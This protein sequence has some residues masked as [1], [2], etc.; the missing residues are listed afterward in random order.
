[1]TPSLKQ[2]QKRIET[3]Q[4]D[5]AGF[6]KRFS[7]LLFFKAGQ[8]FLELFDAE[9]LL[10]ISKGAL[11][12]MQNKTPEE[13][14]VRVYNP[15]FAVEGWETAYTVLELTLKDRPF[16]VD[17]IRAALRRQGL[18][19]YHLLH[20]ILQVSRDASGRITGVSD[21]GGEGVP[22]AYEFYLID[23]IEDEA[24][25]QELQE[26]VTEVLQDVVLATDDYPAMRAQAVTMREYLGELRQRSA[27]EGN[28]TLA[29]ELDEFEAFMAW[30]DADNF[31]FLGY[32]EYD[33]FPIEGVPHLQVTPDSGL[34]ILRKVGQSAY[35]QP[36]PMAQ[37]PQGLRERVTGGRLLLVTKTN[38]ESTLHRAARMDYIGIKKVNADWSVQG[39]QRFLGLFTSKALSAPVEEIP[40]LRRKLRQVLELDRAIPG[41]HDFK[42]IVAIFNS[43][44]REELFW[45]DAERLHQDIRTIMEMERERGVRLTL[46]PDP[47]SRGL[48]AMVIMARDRFNTEVRRRIQSLLT[49]KLHATHVDYQLAMGEDEDQVRF[50]FFFT[51][52][53]RLSELDLQELEHD[54][55]ELT[56]TWEE[57][58]LERI[59]ASRGEME[60]RQLAER[61]LK[62]FDERYKA[63]NSAGVALRDIENI[64]ALGD[65]PYRVDI[66]NPLEDKYGEGATQLKIYHQERTLVLSEVLPLLENLGFRVLEQISYFAQLKE[67]SGAQL[68][69]ID[70]FR[71]QTLSGEM[72]DVRQHAPRL[73]E[74][75]LTLLETRAENDS[76][77]RLVLYGG[78][79]IRQ[80]ALLRAY[81]MYYAQLNAE[82]SRSFINATLVAHP[83]IAKLLYQVFEVRFDPKVSGDREL[84]TGEV[85]EAFVDSL[86][87]VSS[88]PE[89][90]TL[91]GLF[92][93]M[94]ASVRTNFF[95]GKPFISFKLRSERVDAM[96]EPRPMFEIGVSGPGV[97]GTHLRGGKVARGG[98]RWSDRTDD[99]RTEVLGLMKTQMTKNAVIVPVG[100][101]GGFVVK[102]APAER[103]ALRAYVQEQYRTFIRGL[104]DLTDN[105]VDGQVVHLEGL[106]IHDEPDPYLVVAADKGTATFSDLANEIS[107]EYGFWL[108]DAFASGGSYG[109]DHKKEGITARGAWESVKRH[110]RELGVNIMQE[111]FTVFGIGDMSGDVF[112]NGMLYT[113]TIKL[114]AAFNHLHIFLDPQPD[115]KASFVERKRLFEMPRST[116][117]DYNRDLISAGGGIYSRFAKSITLSPQVKAMLGVDADALSGQDLVKAILRMPADLFWNGGIGTYV[118]C[119]AERNAEVGDS[120]ND[121]VRVDASELRVRVVGE[122]GNLGFTQLARIE[123]ARAGGRINTDAIDNSGGVDMSDHEVNIKILLRPLHT[124]GDLSF[125]QRNRLLADMTD[126]VSELVL[127]NNYSQSLS[128]SLAERRSRDDIRLFEGLQEYLMDRGD[129]KPQVEY[130]P[131]RKTYDERAKAGEGLTRPE[132]AILLA[133]TKMGIYRRLLE[134]DF[135][136][137]PYFQHYLFEYFPEVLQTRF[138]D[139]IREHPL[140]REIIATQFTNKVVDLLGI[141]FVHRSLRDTGAS[142]VEV[143]R[144]ALVALEILQVRSFLSQ[145]FALDDAI[146]AGAQYDALMELVRAVEGVVNWILLSDLQIDPIADFV[147]TY[148]GPLVQLREHLRVLL[149]DREKQQYLQRRESVQAQGFPQDVAAEIASLDYLPSSVGVIEV[150]NVSGVA[151]EEAARSF[152]L[153]GDRLRLGWLR[154]TLQDL[155]TDSKWEKIALG[156]LIMDLR[157]AQR[158]LTI[159][160]FQARERGRIDDPHAF[161]QAY[162]RLLQ[163]YD[164]ALRDIRRED[165][166]S[167]AS[168]GVLSRL[169]LQIIEE[170]ARSD[171]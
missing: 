58:L 62:A 123:Y 54:V 67:K 33:I 153:L 22:E 99:F 140:R 18:E 130:L 139:A 95:L 118:K 97:E 111:P 92:N 6:L 68:R 73:T 129:L 52:D 115:P 8:D 23:R 38:A 64:E 166:L 63:Y 40:I 119:S 17:S 55:T 26:T 138:P 51:T 156:G 167:L 45:A 75:L 46:R 93:L 113:D 13:I 168:G 114:Q 56:R 71:V 89:D 34:G 74:A 30:L 159:R 106:V 90:R 14:R 150:S 96:P 135:P 145:I 148:Q 60:G 2:L 91:R 136:D 146:P 151:L 1:M 128:L 76:L 78:L 87:N 43:I 35:Q 121:P 104:L 112:G 155:S 59:I 149:P 142:P 125:V 65:A 124:S 28:L 143:I 101:K 122:G 3:T 48:A 84:L 126:E 21:G 7:E 127:A 157:R 41:S 85:H 116:W 133:Y 117:E 164:A 11:Q 9:G 152:Y 160:Y 50:H 131:G 49:E 88:L 37:L 15:T 120:S 24:K 102:G 137:E 158:Q 36:V 105:L 132:L 10:A 27:Q 98:I 80:V 25:R 20:P 79:T 163:R 4:A 61:Y 144:A 134:T 107:H 103:E 108:G 81:G 94:T 86:A 162:P 109:Y 170:A 57:H 44:P 12:F 77:N 5:D 110:F 154:D 70:I 53:K 83:D 32:R 72:I 39:E 82:V 171:A 16:I 147:A 47:L 42:Q 19:L 141:T 169:I 100:S 161:L 165:S 69:G 31:V 66:V 29:E